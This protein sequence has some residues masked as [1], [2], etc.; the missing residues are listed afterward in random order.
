MPIT[1]RNALQWLAAGSAASL[2]PPFL[3]AGLSPLP[4][5]QPY[6]PQ[7]DSLQHHPCPE[8]YRDAKFGIYFHWGLYSVPAFASEW[9]PHWMYL[10]GRPE[11][12]HHIATYGPLDRF[13]YKDFAAAFTA[14][15]FSPD[16]WVTLFKQ[17]GARYIG[18]VAEH[19]DGFAMWDSHV[20]RWNAKRLGPRRDVVAEM[21]RAVRKQ[22]LKFLTTFHHQWLWG[23]YTSPV[24]EADIYQPQFSDF[25]WPQK[26]TPGSPV[27]KPYTPGNPGAFNFAHPDPPPSSRFCEIWRDKVFEVVDRYQPDLI[28]FDNRLV[29]IPEVY[30]LRMLAHFYNSSSRAGREVVMTYKDT[31]FATGSGLIDIE[32]GQLTDKAS[33]VWQTDDVMDWDSWCY[34]K[35]PNYKPAGRIIHQLIDVVSKNGNL[36]LDVGPRPDG[37]IPAEIESR[38]RQIGSWLK[39]N[40]EAI[41]ETR[42]AE[43]FGEGPTR[44]KKGSYVADHTQDFTAQDIRFTTRPR[45]F[46]V[47]VLGSPGAQVRVASLKRDTPLPFGTLRHAELLGSPAPLRWEWSPDGLVLHIPESRPSQ[48]ALV[49]KLT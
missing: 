7:W 17:A 48:D 16:A 8:W 33:F 41:Y 31:D 10:P 25:Y 39:I 13:G 6:Q 22:G 45:A 23:W 1:R 18:P 32:A 14:E 26:Y 44:V 20:N 42:P 21:E 35:H 4:G 27:S 15:H 46:Y 5:Q 43:R 30:R 40:G 34:L 12:Q 24:L 38:L 19:A 2:V 29:I 3:T 11:Y 49:I 36:L 37:T 47:H 9:Y 28:Y